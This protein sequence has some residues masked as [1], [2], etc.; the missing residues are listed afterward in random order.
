MSAGTDDFGPLR[1]VAERPAEL[2][3]G[4]VLRTPPREESTASSI[5]G[6]R[7]ARSSGTT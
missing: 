6:K 4:S 7:S 3:G 2:L 5:P 1:L